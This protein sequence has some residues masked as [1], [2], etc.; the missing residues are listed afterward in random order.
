MTEPTSHSESR[1]R[2]GK[3]TLHEDA[4]VQTAVY[5]VQP[6]SVFDACACAVYDLFIGVKGLLEI[7]YEGEPERKPRLCDQPGWVLSHAARARHELS[8]PSRT[9]ETIFLLVQASIRGS[10]Y[11]PESV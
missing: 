1:P 6:G 5:R 2:C 11:I 3:A 10:D 4:S 7:R 9:E 8:N